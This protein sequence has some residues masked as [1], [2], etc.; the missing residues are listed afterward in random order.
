[1]SVKELKTDELNTAMSGK[2]F[3]E[4]YSPECSYCRAAEHIVNKL[5]NE[6]CGVDF[7]KINTKSNEN[8]THSFNI[9][10]LPTF[11]MLS[12]GKEVGRAF[13]AKSEKDLK[14]LI[15]LA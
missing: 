3:L 9:R 15:S 2:S 7:Y 12:G 10:S 1:M 6:L 13:G 14:D 4:F 11:V 5:S 8:L